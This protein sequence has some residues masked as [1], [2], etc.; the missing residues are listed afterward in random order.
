MKRLLLILSLLGLAALACST[1][2]SNQ[3]A[4]ADALSESIRLTGTAISADA[5]ANAGGAP[6]ATAAAV[7]TQDHSARDATQTAQAEQVAA[8]AAV[9]ATAVAPIKAELPGYGIDPNFGRA[10][11]IHP[12][13]TL[14]LNGFQVSDDANDFIG[15][16]VEDFVI[17]ADITWNTF[18]GLS[19]CGF[20]LRADG[21]E[22]TPNYYL[23]MATRG[24]NGHVLFANFVNGER[25]ET[26][27]FYAR[28]IDPR[29]QSANDT[30][31]KLTVVGQGSLLTIFTNGTQVGQVINES[32]KDGFVSM[33][34]VSES[35]R[36]VCQFT[37][38]WLWLLD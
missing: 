4:T 31:N 3:E 33:A 38:A 32:R 34:A 37:N 26:Q 5:T 25:K 6:V 27:D 29:F 10:A 14:E 24:A 8:I 7:A 11:W 17:E 30:T 36:T 2:S 21:N 28:G 12:P 9:T 1:P 16:P 19:G 22:E 13:L 20:A 23:V 15:V 35:G 18:T